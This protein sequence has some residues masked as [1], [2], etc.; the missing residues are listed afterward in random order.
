MQLCPVHTQSTY[1]LA[2]QE[3][4]H[5]AFPPEERRP[6]SQQRAYADSNPL[7]TTLAILHQG[8]FA[9]LLTYWQLPGFVYIEHLATRP[10]L[11]GQGLGQQVIALFTST[12]QCPVVLEVEPPSNDLT[13]RR[14]GFYQRCGFRLWSHS[15]YMQP[16][17][18]PHLPQVPLL[19]MAYGQLDEDTDFTHVRQQIHSAVYGIDFKG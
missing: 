16:A 5:Q 4:L 10:E 17:Y 15:P 13:S 12:I 19:L 6:D 18:A 11:R 8:A 3:L 14:I 9:G 2:V 1:Y 7:F